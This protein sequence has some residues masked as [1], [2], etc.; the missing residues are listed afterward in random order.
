MDRIIKVLLPEWTQSIDYNNERSGKSW[1]RRQ[2]FD[3]D[4]NQRFDSINE[5]SS[6]FQFHGALIEFVRKIYSCSNDVRA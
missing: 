5:R 2:W 3:C 4:G 6:L 1:K